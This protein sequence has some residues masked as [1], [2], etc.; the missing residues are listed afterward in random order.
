LS[1]LSTAGEVHDESEPEHSRRILNIT[2]DTGQLIWILVRSINAPQILEVDRSNVYSTI[3][4]ADAVRPL[5]GYVTTLERDADNI[6]FAESNLTEGNLRAHV[7]II[8]GDALQF[9]A[10]LP[11]LFDL[12]FLDAERFN[13][14]C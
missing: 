11:G 8:E 4:F 3:W 2:L 9:L 14:L 13:Y 7:D 12:I 1:R 6:T 10:T 5:G